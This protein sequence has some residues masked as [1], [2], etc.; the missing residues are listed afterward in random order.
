MNTNL[1][2]KHRGLYDDV[3]SLVDDFLVGEISMW[4]RNYTNVMSQYKRI[5]HN[6][7]F[8]KYTPVGSKLDIKKIN[9]E[10]HKHLKN[11][12][13]NIFKVT[14]YNQQS[15]ITYSVNELLTKY[16]VSGYSK[17][18]F[19]TICF[20][21]FQQLKVVPYSERIYYTFKHIF[22]YDKRELYIQPSIYRHLLD[23]DHREYYK[24]YTNQHIN[25]WCYKVNWGGYE[26]QVAKQ[27]ICNEIKNIRID[28]L[29]YE[30]IK[31]KELT[32]EFENSFYI[33]DDCIQIIN[34]NYKSICIETASLTMNKRIHTERRTN[35]TYIVHPDINNNTR[36]YADEKKAICSTPQLKTLYK[37]F[38]ES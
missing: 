5:V 27:E 23:F 33:L 21:L 3:I 13:N 9:I 15:G 14:S 37:Y 6:V 16:K 12:M 10:L 2:L 22:P 28:R 34:V 19:D 4:K 24:F 1:I 26:V 36:L 32:N 31:K 25:K 7:Y 11:K 35:R 29:A 17:V 18:V 30:D 20:K 38:G 8:Y